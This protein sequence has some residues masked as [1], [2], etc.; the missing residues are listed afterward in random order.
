LATPRDFAGVMLV[1]AGL[2][3]SGGLAMLAVTTRR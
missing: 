2:T 1:L 3:A